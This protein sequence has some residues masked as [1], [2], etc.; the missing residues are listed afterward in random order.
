MNMGDPRMGQHMEM[1]AMEARILGQHPGTRRG[2]PIKFLIVALIILIA[3]IVGVIM[4]MDSI[5]LDESE[6]P[7]ATQ[8]RNQP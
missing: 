6:G 4:W 2:S 7:T 5:V 1:R 3:L 8:I